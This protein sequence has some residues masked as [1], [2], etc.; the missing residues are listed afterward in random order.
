M[1]DQE[2]FIT[3]ESFSRAKKQLKKALK[4]EGLEVSLSK[5]ANLIAK[6]FGF[7]D[8]HQIQSFINNNKNLKNKLV[9]LDDYPFYYNITEDETLYF[10][11]I[12]KIWSYVSEYLKENITNIIKNIS[13]F[14][15]NNM[16]SIIKNINNTISTSEYMIKYKTS[17]MHGNISL[18]DNEHDMY[19][20]AITRHRMLE[21]SRITLDN[22]YRLF[23][24]L[25]DAYHN[26]EKYFYLPH[27]ER[28]EFWLQ[29]KDFKS[30]SRSMSIGN[31][32][33]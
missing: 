16:L 17:I 24:E 18:I 5:S 20:M 22:K 26:I 10:N 25:M 8:E 15:N 13:D 23:Y 32:N 29:P 31:F 14:E 12:I 1:K 21:L 3:E 19:A 6:S 4:N 28:K 9:I 30:E 11:E 7:N 33:I 27:D 2:F